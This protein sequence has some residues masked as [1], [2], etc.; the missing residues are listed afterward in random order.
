MA[1]TKRRTPNTGE[2]LSNGARLF[3]AA[4]VGGN[5]FVM[6]NFNHK[7]NGEGWLMNSLKEQIDEWLEREICVINAGLGRGRQD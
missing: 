6:T 4:G 5:L 2:V 7:P 1:G 3:W